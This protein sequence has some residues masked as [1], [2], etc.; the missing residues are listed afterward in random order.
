MNGESDLLNAVN[1][2]VLDNIPL[3][4]M[5]NFCNNG[6]TGYSSPDQW[7]LHVHQ[8]WN[9]SQADPAP[10]ITLSYFISTLTDFYNEISGGATPKSI[11]ARGR[12]WVF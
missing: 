1:T 3:A 10:V 9:E 5:V 11:R 12:T 8:A 7:P 6:F 2:A 4:D